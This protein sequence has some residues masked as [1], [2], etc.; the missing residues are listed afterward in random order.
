MEHR[1]IMGWDNR[2]INIGRDVF[3][4]PVQFLSHGPTGGL[5]DGT[6]LSGRVPFPEPSR[7]KKKL[8]GN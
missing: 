8:M 7:I 4:D 2:N 6:F 3:L 1:G 5:T